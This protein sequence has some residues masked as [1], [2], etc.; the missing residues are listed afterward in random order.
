[1]KLEV[2]EDIGAIIRLEVLRVEHEDVAVDTFQNRGLWIDPP[3][4][5]P[6]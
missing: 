1:M 2:K 5:R 6:S 3:I 4:D